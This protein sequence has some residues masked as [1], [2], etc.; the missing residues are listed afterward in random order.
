MLRKYS[1]I[2]STLAIV[3]A[4]LLVIGGI[5]TA[6]ALESFLS[7]LCFAIGAA[8][9]YLFMHSYALLLETTANNEDALA[10]IRQSLQKT[11]TPAQQASTQRVSVA[12]SP[13]TVGTQNSQAG[14]KT[15]DAPADT[16]KVTVTNDRIICPKC[17]REQPASRRRCFDCGAE[18]LKQNSIYSD[19][20]NPHI[21]VCPNCGARQ[22]DTNSECY[23][24]HTSLH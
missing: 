12:A 19:P 17:G 6:I 4:A 15:P 16:V 7:I 21:L 14:K 2:I 18:F 22:S 5:I 13:I 9:Y 23:Q 1:G 8:L 3:V 20:Q 24:C 10:A 11:D